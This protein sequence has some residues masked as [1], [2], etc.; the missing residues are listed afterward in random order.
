MCSGLYQSNAQAEKQG[1]SNCLINRVKQCLME[2]NFSITLDSKL[3]D[4]FYIVDML[5]YKAF[6][7]KSSHGIYAFGVWGDDVWSY[8]VIQDGDICMLLPTVVSY[9]SMCLL[10]DFLNKYDYS[11]EEKVNYVER[12]MVKSDIDYQDQAF[13]HNVMLRELFKDVYKFEF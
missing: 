4:S 5:T 1:E 11:A 13:R 9:S 10:L 12:Y 6:N 8:Y 2:E 3:W 7:S